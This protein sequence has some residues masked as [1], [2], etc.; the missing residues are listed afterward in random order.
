[1]VDIISGM[2]RSAY[3]P[4][5]G[6]IVMAWGIL[7][8]LILIFGSGLSGRARV[9]CWAG[10]GVMIASVVLSMLFENY[11]PNWDRME[12][13]TRATEGLGM[14][15]ILVG[16]L[17]FVLGGVL[18]ARAM[19]AG[20]AAGSWSWGR[21]SSCWAPRCATTT[22]FPSPGSGRCSAC[23]FA[24]AGSGFSQPRPMRT[25]SP[26]PRAAGAGPVPKSAHPDLCHRNDDQDCVL[27]REPLGVGPRGTHGATRRTTR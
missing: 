16:F 1:M 21:W 8:L 4:V 3:W 19:L 12:P 22:A 11:L 20:L 25:P 2:F 17:L 10:L 6:A 14:A 23:S 24:P 5:L 9:F 15:G 27:F 7:S 13:A 18:L 26:A